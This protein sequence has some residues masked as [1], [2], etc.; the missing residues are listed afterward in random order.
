MAPKPKRLPDY[1]WKIRDLMTVYD[2]YH[3]DLPVNHEAVYR[4]EER[5]FHLIC[6]SHDKR[7]GLSSLVPP[8]DRPSEDKPQ[9]GN[10]KATIPAPPPNEEEESLWDSEDGV[11]APESTG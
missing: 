2:F 8:G 9:Q 10:V 5:L 3:Y 1:V 4:A 7:K 11:S 6:K